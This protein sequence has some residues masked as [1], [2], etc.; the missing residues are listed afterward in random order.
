MNEANIQEQINSINQKLDTL[1]DYVNR[2]RI[3]SEM[4]D[5]LVS[6]GSIVVR[7][8]FKSTIEELDKSG[9]DLNME[10]VK[11]LLIKLVKNVP[12]FINLIDI[13]Q[14]ILDFMNDA[15]PLA[16]EMIVDSIKK[17][18]ELEENG[19]I[20]SLKKISSNLSQP[21]I[22]K[23]LEKISSALL[24]VEPDEEKD[25]KSLW[26]LFKDM[27]S[28]E[29]KKSLSYSIRLLKEINNQ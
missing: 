21:A 2:Q 24:T 4:V 22:F 19:T 23:K 5:D 20:D 6:D 14:S 16:R 9:V 1:L 8:V 28:P 13:M 10:E 11:T 26:K 7:D 15:T 18:H 17:L 27:R 3:K 12:T 25:N 29:V